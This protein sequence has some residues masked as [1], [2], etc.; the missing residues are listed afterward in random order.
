[1][2]V[3]CYRWLLDRLFEPLTYG[4]KGQETSRVG[5]SAAYHGVSSSRIAWLLSVIRRATR[6]HGGLR[7]RAK[8]VSGGTRRLLAGKGECAKREAD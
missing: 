4:M 6:D 1:M 2:V 3:S 7:G 8:A 5:R